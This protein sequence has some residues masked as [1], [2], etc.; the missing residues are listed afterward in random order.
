MERTVA[1]EPF[2]ERVVSEGLI[3]PEGPVLDRAGNLHV[4]DIQLGCLFRIE[5]GKEPVVAAEVGGG[6]NGATLAPDG[7]IWVANSGGYDQPIREI[8]S[9]Q[10]PANRLGNGSIQRVDPGSGEV[11]VIADNL[12]GEDIGEANDLVFDSHGNLY[13]TNS[14]K[15]NVC[16]IG[17][18]REVRRIAEGMVF[19]N[20]LALIEEERALL[21]SETMTGVIYRFPI[22]EPGVLGARVGH[23][24]MPIS[25]APWPAMRD[26]ADG[27][28]VGADDVLLAAGVHGGEVVIF[29]RRGTI[30]E[31][32]S[33][34]GGWIT[35]LCFSPDDPATIFVTDAMFGR[36]LSKPLRSARR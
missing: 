27:L 20:G 13:F 26:G 34:S 2:A 11:E 25:P 7:S 15:G 17:A 36:V 1:P 24:L 9:G 23:A 19:S 10:K 32:V 16:F 3:F 22:E 6:P 12:E 29:D 18:D 14:R 21:V 28:K 5:D 4:V 30:L 8:A 31:T 35:N 33:F